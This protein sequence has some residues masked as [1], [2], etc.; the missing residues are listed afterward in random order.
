MDLLTPL[1]HLYFYANLK[2]IPF[3]HTDSLVIQLI[4]KMNLTACAD[5]QACKISGGNKRKLIT[6]IS[7]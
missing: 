5:I 4:H 7:I 1:E 6:A 2:Y 3:G